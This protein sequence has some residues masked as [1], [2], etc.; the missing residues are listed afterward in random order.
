M[1]KSLKFTAPAVA[2]ALA[3]TAGTAVA[4]DRDGAANPAIMNH[5]APVQLAASTQEPE[6]SFEEEKA[7]AEKTF[8]TWVEQLANHAE[9]ADENAQ[10]MAQDAGDA[11]D[12]AWTEVRASWEEVKAASAEN[13]EEVKAK[14]DESV[15]RLEAAWNELQDG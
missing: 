15:E 4:A 2:A 10:E 7:E 13:W 5:S 8:D 11:L 9:Q 1:L 12:E 6:I 14:F 3:L